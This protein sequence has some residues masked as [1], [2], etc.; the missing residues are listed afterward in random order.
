MML[1]CLILCLETFL[2]GM[3]TGKCFAALKIVSCLETFLSGMETSGNDWRER[4]G[5]SPLKPSL[6]E[7]KL[8]KKKVQEALRKLLETFLSGMETRIKSRH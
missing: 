4:T 3:E 1:V 5:R 8:V 7:W 6:V 2:S